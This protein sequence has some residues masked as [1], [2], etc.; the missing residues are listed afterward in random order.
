M[1]L[2]KKKRLA[3]RTL[4]VGID[5][6][7]FVPGKIDEL[8]EAITKQDIRD[9]VSS[10]AIMLKT[11]KGRRKIVKKTGRRSMGTIRKKMRKRK[12]DYMHLTRKLRKYA[13]QLKLQSKLTKD[14]YQKAR[15]QIKSKMFKSKSHFKELLGK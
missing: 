4:H 8:K 1:N 2:K 3:A 5:R 9:L 7:I 11:E 12:E 14:E 6:I 15:K 13:K 10:G